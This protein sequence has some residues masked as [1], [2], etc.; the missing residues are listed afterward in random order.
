M[1]SLIAWLFG[2]SYLK[3][4]YQKH[5]DNFELKN[6]FWNKTL[7]LFNIK[8]SILNTE[9]IPETGPV[10]VVCNHPFGLVDGLII[11]D[12]ISKKRK[13][14]RILINDEISQV[15]LIRPYLFPLKLDEKRE[16]V[17]FNLKSKN[18]AIRHVQNGGALI[19]FPS[20]EVA[21]KEKIFGKVIEKK[22]QSILGAIIRKTEATICPVYFNGE[23]SFLF[24]VL[25]I[26]HY[27]LRRILF[28]KELINKKNKFFK[29]VCLPTH[30]SSQFIGKGNSEISNELREYTLKG[31][32]SFNN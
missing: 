32:Q 23:N 1:K 27:P 2:F 8:Y 10:I 7:D 17:K 3:K 19:I 26:I 28:A 11:A 14:Y 5:Y 29:A 6:N 31:K 24:H 4:L 21:T 15:G 22:W 9:K 12:T 16:S 18:D 30:Y 25:G 13:D 20:G